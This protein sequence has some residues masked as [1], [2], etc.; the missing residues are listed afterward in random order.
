MSISAMSG[1]ASRIVFTPDT[2]SPTASTVWPRR[3]SFRPS[4]SRTS[5]L[6]STIT[7]RR[8]PCT[9]VV[10]ERQTD[11]ELA[12]FAQA[13]AVRGDRAAVQLDEIL[14]EREADAHPALRPPDRV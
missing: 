4:S 3:R 10:R 7:I 11:L 14:H 6:S 12:S 8:E 9:G 13:V 5:T 2:P 1:F